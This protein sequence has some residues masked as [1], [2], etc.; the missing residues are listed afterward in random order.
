LSGRLLY[1]LNL[2]TTLQVVC[3]NNVKHR[4]VFKKLAS[5]AAV[6][7]MMDVSRARVL[8]SGRNSHTGKILKAPAR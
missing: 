6:A 4:S 1:N 2:Y 7:A 8:R 3:D 5:A